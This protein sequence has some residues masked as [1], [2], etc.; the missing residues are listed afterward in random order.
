MF[1]DASDVS[2]FSAKRAAEEYTYIYNDWA[3]AC[4]KDTL[5]DISLRT[6][7]NNNKS[8]WTTDDQGGLLRVGAWEFWE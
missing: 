5:H 8:C 3:R 1:M 7:K 2:L 6:G 4:S